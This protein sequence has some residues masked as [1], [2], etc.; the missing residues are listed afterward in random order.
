MTNEV[1]NMWDR[2]TKGNFF[3]KLVPKVGPSKIKFTRQ[4]ESLNRLRMGTTRY[5]HADR[6]CGYCQKKVTT[7]HILFQ[8]P[9]LAMLTCRW[10][11][12]SKRRPTLETTRLVMANMKD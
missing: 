1:Q 9:G 5:K 8:C 2:E 11:A 12:H 4:L 6:E 3:R 10:V 7:E